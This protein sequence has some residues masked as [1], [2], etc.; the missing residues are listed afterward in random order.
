MDL[1]KFEKYVNCNNQR[2]YKGKYLLECSNTSPMLAFLEEKG[3]RI[4]NY[5]DKIIHVEIV[6]EIKFK[7]MNDQLAKENNKVTIKRNPGNIMKKIKEPIKGI[8]NADIFPTDTSTFSNQSENQFDYLKGANYIWIMSDYPSTLDF[9]SLYIDIP[10]AVRKKTNI[11]TQFEQNVEAKIYKAEKDAFQQ[12]YQKETLQSYYKSKEEYLK[13]IIAIDKPQLVSPL[14]FGYIITTLTFANIHYYKTEGCQP[15]AS[16]LVHNDVRGTTFISV[17]SGEFLIFLAREIDENYSKRP[18]FNDR[19]RNLKAFS[20]GKLQ[21]I[22]LTSEETLVFPSD[23]VNEIYPLTNQCVLYE[24][25]VYNLFLLYKD[26][27]Q[28]P[29]EPNRKHILSYIFEKC[30]EVLDLT[31]KIFDNEEQNN[32]FKMADILASELKILFGIPNGLFEDNL[33]KIA[34]EKINKK[35]MECGSLVQSYLNN[36]K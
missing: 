12:E 2:L 25:T 10:F 5:T 18:Y 8:K 11:F 19:E 36:I 24:Q 4:I 30:I 13:A 26:V 17:I 32:L 23:M 14:C 15:I 31:L 27:T 33:K 21:A 22:Y 29:Q 20:L 16:Q 3:A 34:R 7:T 28:L 1:T 35:C 9:Y 6:R